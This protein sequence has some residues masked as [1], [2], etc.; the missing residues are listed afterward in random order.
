MAR[1]RENLLVTVPPMQ[2]LPPTN[3]VT[4]ALLNVRSVVAKLADIQADYELMSATVLCFCETWLSPAQPSPVIKANHVVLRCDRVMNDHKGGTM[5]SV[6]SNMQP[7]R[8]ATVVSYGME[9]VVT[10]LNINGKKLQV[11]VVYKSPSVSVPHFV[12]W[13]TRLLQYV[14]TAGIATIVLG[15]VN[16]DI[17]CNSGS[18][19]ERLMSSHGYTS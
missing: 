10:I 7:S 2:C 12:Q 14:S 3:H 19:V 17:L 15:D 5:L 8:S 16:D 9:S 6:P 4:L 13:M 11:A 1:L 18:Q